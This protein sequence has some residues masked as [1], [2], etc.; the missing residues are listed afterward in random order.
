MQDLG[1]MPQRMWVWMK[2]TTLMTIARSAE[3]M[4]LSARGV[5]VPLDALDRVKL[6]AILHWD[7]NHFVVLKSADASGIV[8]HDPAAGV[9]RLSMAEVSKHFT[10]VALELRPTRGF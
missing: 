5:Q 1:G 4:T 7:M 8:I 3:P 9:R 10:G 2:G 6:P